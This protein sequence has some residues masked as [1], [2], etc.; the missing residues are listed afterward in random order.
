MVEQKEI[1]QMWDKFS[2]ETQYVTLDGKIP[3]KTLM[4]DFALYVLTQA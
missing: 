2:K 3:L 1:E 4:V